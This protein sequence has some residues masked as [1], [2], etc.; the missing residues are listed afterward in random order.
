MKNKVLFLQILV[1]SV[2]SLSNAQEVPILDYMVDLNNQVKLTVASTED[3][4]YVLHVRHNS[5]DEF[6]QATAIS[7]GK[8]GTITL[9]EPL[10][11][12]PADHYKVT[13]Y[14]ISAP[15]DTDS[16]GLNDLVELADLST[17]SPLNS[18]HSID[19]KDG[20]VYISDRSTFKKLSYQAPPGGANP[21]VD[22]F[23]ELKFF[24]HNRDAAEPE[25]YFINSNTH[26]LHTH[27]ANSIGYTNDGTLMT[28]TITFH[29][30]VVAPNGTL[31][32]YRFFFQPNNSFSFEYIQKAMELLAANMPFLKNNLCYYPL[33]QVGLPLYFQE[34]AKYDAS[35]VCVLFE[36]DLYADVNYLA[37]HVAEGYGLLRVMNANETPNSRDVVLYEALPNELPRVGGMITT[38][39]Q[40]PL[41]HVNLRAIQ[42]NVPNAFIRDALQAPGID[43]LIG[44]YVYY[45]ADRP[46]FTIRAATQQEVDAFYESI[47]PSIGQIPIRDLSKTKIKPLD[48]ISFAESASFGVKCANVATMRG[49]GFPEGTIPDGFGIP[50]YFYDAFMQYNGLY[51]KA[52]NMLEDA[53]FQSD[54]NIQILRLAE[55]RQTIKEAD[56][57]SWMMDELKAM[58]QSF[59]AGSSIRCRS[60]TNNEDLPGF[61]G[62]GLYDSYTQHPDEGHISKSIK[63]VYA[64]LWNF[65]AFDER[66]FY[67]VDHF[68]TAMGVLLHPNHENEQANG[69][70]VSIDPI[71]QTTGTYYLN[72]QVGEDLVTN[73]NALSVPEEILLDAISVTDDDY[74]V[75]NPSNQ[76]PLDTLILKAPNLDQMRVFLSTI[77][78]EFQVLYDAVGEEGFAMEIEYKINA[79]GALVIKQARPW[80]SFWAKNNPPI[81]TSSTIIGLKV[82]PNPFG[83]VLYLDCA[84]ETEIRLE[85]YTALGQKVGS[86]LVDFRK[87]HR[88]LDVTQL[89]VGVYFLRGLDSFGGRYFSGK[90]LKIR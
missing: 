37:L 76:V 32:T 72:T 61:S 70:G 40:T 11:A 12:Y 77:H 50:F 80:A 69:V 84:C 86:E 49:F 29:P 34:L 74:F 47:R 13:E 16:D 8:N 39:M 24:I 14:L 79:E 83:D 10:S 46:N 35:R 87:S 62:A 41:S 53:A 78:Q 82:Y 65:R 71:Y 27:F 23:E 63:Q 67:R 81:D 85:I 57:P 44:K 36:D 75:M 22:D 90:V 4:Y 89:E 1:W 42:D 58:Q 55:F 5:L 52:Q 60:S 19:F 9:T 64:S 28:G 31:G 43:S 51:A 48:S 25:L 68:M 2:S 59:P 73:P 7:I 30:F 56:M 26:T 88:Q 45:K 33:E 54:F 6:E 15:V 3:H 66:E 18:A 38:V 17:K 20:V 21:T